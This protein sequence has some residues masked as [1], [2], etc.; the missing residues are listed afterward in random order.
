MVDDD[1][2][3][4]VDC[5]VNADP[6]HLGLNWSLT[7]ETYG[8]AK[9]QPQGLTDLVSDM[10]RNHIARALL[11]PPP[12]SAMGVRSRATGGRSRPCSSFPTASA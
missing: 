5:Y 8:P 2:P 4:I 9:M 12:E 6:P 3:W 11:A 7:D 1:L 10:D